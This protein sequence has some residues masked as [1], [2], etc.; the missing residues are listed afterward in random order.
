MKKFLFSLLAVAMAF[1]MGLITPVQALEFA[2]AE[3]HLTNTSVETLEKE[4]NDKTIGNYVGNTA[5]YISDVMIGNG[6][7]E[8]EAKKA[9]HDK[10]Y[11]VY[12]CDLNEGTDNKKKFGGYLVESNRDVPK[13]YVYLG[14][15]ITT[16]RTKAI[17]D[18][19]VMDQEGGYAA[20]DYLNFANDHMPGVNNMAYGMTFACGAVRD[21]LAEGSHAAKVAKEYLDLFYVPNTSKGTT[22]DKLGDYLLSPYRSF[23]DYKNLRLVLNTLVL[24]VVDG[25]LSLGQSDTSLELQKADGGMNA[26]GTVAS[27]YTSY[28]GVVSPTKLIDNND[29]LITA[30][31]QMRDDKNFADVNKTE[32]TA[33]LA[34]IMANF[35]MQL[36][37]FKRVLKDGNLTDTA[38]KY[39]ESVIIEKSGGKISA[40]LGLGTAGCNAYQLL[41]LGSDKMLCLFFSK[42]K[43]YSQNNAFHDA[44][45][46]CA[47][48]YQ[49]RLPEGFN[50]DR[51]Y[52]I[53]WAKSA[54][55]AIKADQERPSTKTQRAS[56]NE[57][58]D[59]FINYMQIY[60]T[61]YKEG[62][63]EY[64][65]NGNKIVL[66]DKVTDKS[67]NYAISH[68]TEINNVPY[69]FHLSV[70]DAFSNYMISGNQSLL[71]YLINAVDGK[72]IG[73]ETAR[74]A[75]FPVVRVLGEA[76]MFS[77][78]SRNMLGF[79]IDTL[80]TENELGGTEMAYDDYR[81]GFQGEGGVN[82]EGLCN[83][84][85]GTHKDL[86]EGNEFVAVTNENVYKSILAGKKNKVFS[87]EI[88]MTE[89]LEA[90]L[91]K[92]AIAAG[93]M[94]A[95]QIVFA[96]TSA[97]IF[98]C[99]EAF[100]AG[101]LTM[102][103][104]A[105][106]IAAGICSCL[107]TLAVVGFVIVVLVAIVFGIL[108][109][110]QLWKEFYAPVIYTPM[111]T[112]MIDSIKDE[113][114]EYTDFAKYYIVRN[115]NGDP[116]DINGSVARKWLA[117][118]YTKDPSA[119][120]P[121]ILD[122]DNGFFNYTTGTNNR[123]DEKCM[124]LAR[125]RRSKAFNLNNNCY[126]DR[127]KST[128]QSE[129]GTYPTVSGKYLYFY[130]EDSVAGKTNGVL[131]G[132][133]ISAI[134]IAHSTTDERS[135]W[136]LDNMT[137]Y[138]ILS[139]TN[140][141]P[142]CKYNTYIAYQ[143]TNDPNEAIRDIRAAYM[144][145]AVQ[146][147]Y[148]DVVYYNVLGMENVT[149]KCPAVTCG[150]EGTELEETPFYYSLYTAKKDS[151]NQER[152]DLVGDPILTDSLSYVSNL[153]D[154]KEGYDVVSYFAGV[155][156]DFNSF[157]KEGKETFTRHRYLC[158][159]SIEPKIE[160]AE[161]KD[162]SKDSGDTSSGSTSSGSTSSGSTDTSDKTKPE[163]KKEEPEQE[164][165]AGFAFFAGSED[166]LG[167]GSKPGQTMQAYA[168]DSYGAKLIPTNL[169]PSLYYNKADR[170]YLG[171]VTTKN[172]KKA[173][174][175]IAVFTGEPKSSYL[176]G[177]ITVGNHSYCA[178]DV[179]TQ[180][181]YYFYGTGGGYRQR[182]VRMSHAYFTTA[183]PEYYGLYWYYPYDFYTYLLPRAL[184]GCGPCT[185]GEPIK[186]EDVLFSVSSDAAPVNNSNNPRTN[187]HLYKLTAD[188][189]PVS[190]D[191]VTDIGTNW[192]S[193]HSVDHYYYDEYDANGN[194]LSSFDMGLGHDDPKGD[195]SGTG[196]LYIY[197]RSGDKVRRR[198]NYVSNI[199]L[200]GD[201]K[202][203]GYDTKDSVYN[204][205][206][207]SAL[208]GAE[209]I[210]NID[211]PMTLTD[212]SFDLG[213][214]RAMY[215][216]TGSASAFVATK[217]TVQGATKNYDDNCYLISVSY[218]DLA[219]TSVR[220]ARVMRIE[221]GQAVYDTTLELPIYN[222]D[223]P[224]QYT[225]TSMAT[226]G[227]GTYKNSDGITRAAYSGYFMYTSKSGYPT[228][229]VDVRFINLAPDTERSSTLSNAGTGVAEYY[230][231]DGNTTDPFL[232]KTNNGKTGAAI[233]LQSYTLDKNGQNTDKYIEDIVIADAETFDGNMDLAAA[234]LGA[235]GYPYIIDFD[236]SEGTRTDGKNTVSA[237]GIRRTNSPENAIKDIRISSD[238]LGKNFDINGIRYQ[239]VNDN[240][241]ILSGVDKDGVYLYMTYGSSS[242][243]VLWSEILDKKIPLD[244]VDWFNLDR[245]EA[246][247]VDP[248]F[249]DIKQEYYSKHP[250][251]GE[252][253]NAYLAELEKTKTAD[254]GLKK[255]WEQKTA[256]TNI[257][258]APTANSPEQDARSAGGLPTKDIYWAGCSAYNED[259]FI[260]P[261][262]DNT[263]KMTVCA[264]DGTETLSGLR[265]TNNG[266]KRFAPFGSKEETADTAASVFS[267]PNF[268]IIVIL[269]ALF[270]SGLTA[271]Y[272]I[273]RKKKTV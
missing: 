203:S 50:V 110:V 83:V 205:T 272:I 55:D 269:S 130:T 123:P 147:A 93:S 4:L 144:T 192:R 146:L 60:A 68:Q 153:S 20:F 10:G 117:L 8:A 263:A 213:Q 35:G 190:L 172:P 189:D 214:N 265:F 118:Y 176:P 33:E 42:M 162:D 58:I 255:D 108:Y 120:S 54:V 11:M 256:L 191:N 121:L 224:V 9:L 57:Q 36:A 103:A 40:A 102:G 194:L 84:W 140:L 245:A 106:A 220:S 225:Q 67:I 75:V 252:S 249:E 163:E 210:V 141:S 262:T 181:D 88:P 78:K 241:V 30:A 238:N 229:R 95:A 53:D 156:L 124:P 137:D 48:D 22:G 247:A 70:K 90:H 268:W 244:E 38:K 227:N 143:T 49:H 62:M 32:V 25:Q 267:N 217:E 212:K 186:I 273:Y 215:I 105:A 174:T 152:A 193:V 13:K 104:S 98:A 253:V 126:F 259:K 155:P 177:A 28:I 266:N 82:E 12:D 127:V 139:E 94:V 91:I 257:G 76:R 15:K 221:H 185:G 142:D 197:Y 243:T 79:L 240:P 69:L 86:T 23:D 202:I 134:T 239:R 52:D 125:F 206:V 218:S 228:N 235:M 77:I 161:K 129:D 271:V 39:L 184:Y 19:K 92:I 170:T 160:D 248:N 65:K 264:L 73:D 169:T 270:I 200:S 222:S 166:W 14:Y 260:V 251:L 159:S 47:S 136:H 211:N 27:Q 111:P 237:L 99:V 198:G 26:D 21:R 43:V 80:T 173:L 109:L 158:Y 171:Y 233:C 175:D 157:D 128:K 31:E 85:L 223:T 112:V 113:K 188:S 216:Y 226:T 199:K 116:A 1:V 261:V 234:K 18:L 207:L 114:G 149:R 96:A 61:Q 168:K 180:G 97:A 151:F 242:D 24:N 7:T 122:P 72:E 133:Y 219:S 29:W 64:E 196:H 154:V 148:G 209:D 2:E 178:C 115:Q 87:N 232:F 167:D 101:W 131:G 236:I 41:T 59:S 71:D 16:D 250:G 89:K 201:N 179:F 145:D 182:S 164:Y 107:A 231:G 81:L 195:T 183:T 258:F 230:V 44:L 187:A 165:L 6:D 132:K 3:S 150:I 74:A 119:G 63:K 246:V 46:I 135:I 138:E 45:E 56:Y 37:T 208:A 17:T 5:L 100:G 204:M 254:L 66:P 51:N 34:E